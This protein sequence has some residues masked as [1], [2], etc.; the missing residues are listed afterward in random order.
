MASMLRIGRLH[1]L[2]DTDIQARFDH[3]ELARRMISGGA[4][5]VQYREK[6]AGTRS[7]IATA[8]AIASECRRAGVTFIVN[9]RVDVAVASDADGV[10]LGQDD[11]P[12]GL[13]R[14]ILGPDR[15]VGASV[16]DPREGEAAWKD[17]A[18]YVGLGPVFGTAT[19]SDVGPVLGVEGLRE[20]LPAFRLPVIAIGGIATGRV[21]EIFGAGV[22]GVAVLSA[23]CTA[24]DPEAATREIREAIRA[25]EN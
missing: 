21:R 25:A 11:F 12:V 23:V 22:H 10:H 19:K 2:T 14:R 17:G 24:D 18:D 15:I 8:R 7:M 5:V 16:D 1:T 4:D 9:D 20:R 3:V 6:G 13:A